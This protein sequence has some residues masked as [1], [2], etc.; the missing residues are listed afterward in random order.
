[1]QLLF[2]AAA[3]Q[4]AFGGNAEPEPTSPEV[5][6]HR[7][8]PVLVWMRRARQAAAS[9][10]LIALLIGRVLR[11][12]SSRRPDADRSPTRISAPSER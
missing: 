3:S 11:R 9:S 2:L 7:L 6:V 8:Y 10:S 1:M 5:P 12:D 4:V